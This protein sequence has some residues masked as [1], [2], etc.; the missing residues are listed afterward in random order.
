VQT[1]S[2]KALAFVVSLF[3]FTSNLS[4]SF[5]PI[6]FKDAGLS[7]VQI[8]QILF[9]TFI[10]IGFLPVVLLKR[11]RNFERVIAFGI[12]ATMIF[13]IVLIYVREPVIL[14]LAYGVSTATFWP[15]FNLLQFKLSESKVRARTVSLFSS[16]IPSI[17]SIVGPAT[18]GFII[19][20][21]GFAV[22]FSVSITLYLV[23]FVFSVRIRYSPEAHEF[24]IPRNRVFLVFFITFILLGL[25]EAYWLAYPFFVEEISGSILY[26][27]LVLTISAV[28]ISAITYLVNWFSDI[29]KARVEFA[30]IGSMLYFCWFAMIGFALTTYEIVVLSLISG[31]AGAFNLS[32]FAYYAD[33]FDREHYASILVMMEVGLMIGRI[34][35]L[36]PTYVFVSQGNYASYFISLGIVS[37]GLIP[38]FVLSQKRV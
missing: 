14:G 9:V 24:S 38:F 27:G 17:A 7:I 19:E 23:A 3:F 35:N 18:G 36:A 32:W 6:Y 8:I 11:V 28:I 16:I 22:L 26:M 2:I 5:L 10:V 21:F 20:R 15:S 4:G 13:Y 33:S 1:I 37:L 29:K 31:L 30:V 34:I 25:S 12:F